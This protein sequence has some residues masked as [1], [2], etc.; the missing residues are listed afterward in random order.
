MRPVQEPNP[1]AMSPFRQLPRR[2]TVSP[3]FRNFRASIPYKK[4]SFLPPSLISSKLPRSDGSG[5]LIVPDPSRS[6]VRMGQ[7][8]SEWWAII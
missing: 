2:V 1:T 8:P 4:I 3:S 5:P 6:P 7:P